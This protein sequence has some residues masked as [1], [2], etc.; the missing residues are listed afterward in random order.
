LKCITNRSNAS[1]L[2][3][4]R[5]CDFVHKNII[6]QDSASAKTMNR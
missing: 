1:T 5:L 4:D 6:L 2:A 3:T